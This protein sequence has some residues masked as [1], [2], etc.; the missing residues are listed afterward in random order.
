MRLYVCVPLLLGAAC[1]K[2]SK[3]DV[4][5]PAPAPVAHDALP[6]PAKAEPFSLAVVEVA[7]PPKTKRKEFSGITFVTESERFI[8]SYSR[9]DVYSLFAGR[10]V[11]YQG[12]LYEPELQAVVG[13]HLRPGMVALADPTGEDL[14]LSISAAQ[15]VCGQVVTGLHP[16]NTKQGGEPFHRFQ[17]RG[18][19]HHLFAQEM[20]EAGAYQVRLRH[21]EV[22]PDFAPAMPVSMAIPVSPVWL[23][24]I[25]SVDGCIE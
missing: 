5:E 15:R 3:D 11:R 7:E 17:T 23:D 1:G 24:E 16:E 21:L 8:V 6:T 20:P 25:K 18:K 12:E 2:A 19:T 13:P 4:G 9:A 14:Y 10:Q 22:N